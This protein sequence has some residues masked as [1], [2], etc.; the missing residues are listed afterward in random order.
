MYNGALDIENAWRMKFERRAVLR[1][2]SLAC[3]VKAKSGVV[4]TPESRTR[5]TDVSY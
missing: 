2:I 5:S 3:S 4:R 1:A